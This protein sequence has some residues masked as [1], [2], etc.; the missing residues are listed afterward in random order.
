MTPA[1]AP[2][3]MVRALRRRILVVVAVAVVLIGIASVWGI[4]IVTDLNAERQVHIAAQSVA[5]WGTDEGGDRVIDSGRLADVDAVS[6]V[7]ALLDSDGGVV[8][9]SPAP[10][11]TVAALERVAAE[12]S[13]SRSVRADLGG[14][15]ILFTDIALPAGTVVDDGARTPV[16][17]ALVG[18]GVEGSDRLVAALALAAAGTLAVVLIAVW[19]VVTLVVSRTTRALTDLTERV[20]RGRLEALVT[21]PAAE[22]SETRAIS[23]AIARLDE[24]RDATEHQLRDFVAD[25]SHELRTPLTTIQGWAEL[26]FQSPDDARTT[27]RAFASIV[28]E[29]ERMR[30]L[31]DRLA[32]LARAEGAPTISEPVDLAAV[33]RAAADDAALL[34]PER[35]I[36]VHSPE[37]VEVRGDPHALTQVV[38]NLVGNAVVH[39]GATASV[40]ITLAEGPEGVELT[41]AD[42]GV[43][44]PPALR[45]RAFDRFVTGDRRT[46]TG[47]GLAIAQAIISAHGGTIALASEP[48][49]GTRVTVRLPPVG[50]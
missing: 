28:E 11:V 34:A 5:T 41:V 10:A 32:Q 49:V 22:Y 15:T 30:S 43:G 18:I 37:R 4:R 14:R 17:R 39:A 46:G 36:E 13:E 1:R 31:V 50:S 20:E 42:D 26:H 38:R 25:A 24:R 9:A 47:L 45:R 7:V 12:A 29:S 44:I 33:C 21:S 48:G 40:T 35:R 3:S 19:G 16:E 6:T 2:A 8:A 27:E 23:S